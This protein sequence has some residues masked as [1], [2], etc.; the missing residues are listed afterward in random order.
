MGKINVICTDLDGILNDLEAFNEWMI[1]DYFT[2]IG[3]PVPEKKN[4]HAYDIRDIYELSKILRDRIWI[5]Y[6]PIYCQKFGPR[7]NAFDVLRYWQENNKE[8]NVTTARAFVTN[9]FFGK[10]ARN[11]V[12]MWL[13]ENNFKPNEIVWSSEKNTPIQKVEAYKQLKADFGIDDKPDVL[14]ALLGVCD[15]ATI[16][17]SHN[18]LYVPQAKV[19]KLYRHD[20]FLQIKDTVDTLDCKGRSR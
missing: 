10:I 7:S 20:N 6:Y 16:N 18:A 8:V 2:S 12:E 13:Q 11:W 17:T 14:D 4:P 15:M 5:I 19:Y 9:L 3:K 1:K